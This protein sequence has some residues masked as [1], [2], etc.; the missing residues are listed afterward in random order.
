[1][2]V[3]AKKKRIKN[4]LIIANIIL[5]SVILVLLMAGIFII[6]PQQLNKASQLHQYILFDLDKSHQNSEFALNFNE[7]RKNTQNN[8]YNKIAVDNKNKF[9]DKPQRH[10]PRIAI[11]ITN[12]GLN[13]LLTELALTMPPSIAL[14]FLPYTASL[15]PLLYKARQDGHEIYLNIP[16]E[17]DLYS[18]HGLNPFLTIDENVKKL[19]NI[20]AVCNGCHGVYSN[21]KDN[22]SNNPQFLDII[23]HELELQK[24]IFIF[25]K[26]ASSLLPEHVLSNK[27]IMPTSIIIDHEAEADEIKEKLDLLVRLALA[28]NVALGYAHG[29]AITM[30]IIKDWLPIL[31]NHNVELVPVSELYEEHDL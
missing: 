29:Y 15:K 18:N 27:Q 12:L 19:K 13:K 20:L 3:Y 9:S 17:T 4:Y 16:F 2:D 7:P 11:I 1:M 23:L 28:E 10:N 30:E 8:K 5:G 22:L 24:L 26:D 31:K 6:Q 14:G 21:Y 25:G